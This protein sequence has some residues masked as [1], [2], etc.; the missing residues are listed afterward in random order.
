MGG[1]MGRGRMGGDD[2]DDDADTDDA[3]TDDDSEENDD[4]DSDVMTDVHPGTDTKC[5]PENGHMLDFSAAV[6]T[7]NNLGG[8]GPDDGEQNIRYRGVAA[9]EGA[10]VDLVVSATS[11]YMP[12]DS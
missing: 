4:D 2:D 12:K 5:D 11:P 3:D 9:K 8:L 7:H 1:T 6:V 10:Q